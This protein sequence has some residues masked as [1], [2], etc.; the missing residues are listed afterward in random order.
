MVRLK[1]V[2]V[3][4]IL[5]T[6]TAIKDFYETFSKILDETYVGE[7]FYFADVELLGRSGSDE[8][9]TLIDIYRYF[10]PKITITTI[11][12]LLLTTLQIGR[13]HVRRFN[14]KNSLLILDEFHLLTPQMIAA[15]RLLLKKLSQHYNISYLFMSATPSP[16]YGELLKDAL[17]PQ[18]LKT[19]ILRDEYR[20]LARHKIE[21]CDDKRVEDLLMEKRD[22]LF[23]LRTL[24]IV[25]TVKKA[26]KIYRNLK[27]ELGNRRN[28][29]L[30][31]GD[32]AYKDRMRKEVEID[33]ADILVSTQVAEISLDVSFDLLLTELSPIPSLIQRFGRVNRYGS[34]SEKTNVFIAEPEHPQP[35]GEILI[36][37]SR[38][39]LPMLLDTLKRK[40]EEAY[41]NEEFWEY[42]RA[43]LTDVKSVEEKIS[44]KMDKMLSFFSFLAREEEI[45]EMLG[46]EETFLAIPKIYL[47][48]V[49]KLYKK[50]EDTTYE[51]R[52]KLYAEI[53]GNFVPISRSDIRSRKAEWCEELK[54]PVIMNYDMDVGLIRVNEK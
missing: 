35:Y 22:L 21:Y 19:M 6:I 49:L 41:L 52:K 8:E 51:G 33:R 36:S 10:I 24:I 2:K 40:G 38:E 44:G 43:Y 53:K 31:H 26:Q 30:I 45:I 11:D 39:N 9:E 20:C 32:F 17:Q 18:P 14:L 47:E 3:F 1:P 15:L 34:V 25:N 54:L 13:Y 5:P 16:V 12:Q 46:R 48:E 23:G 42:E 29:V 50:L 37:N 28:I 4:Y 27:E 7:Y